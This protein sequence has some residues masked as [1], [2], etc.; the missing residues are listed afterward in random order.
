[1]LGKL[2]KEYNKLQEKHA[3]K[4]GVVKKLSGEN[5]NLKAKIRRKYKML[6]EKGDKVKELVDDKKKQEEQLKEATQK[7][8]SLE[9]E[10]GNSKC[11]V[12]DLKSAK[13]GLSRKVNMLKENLSKVKLGDVTTFEEEMDNL[14]KQV[15]NLNEENK[16]LRQLVNLLNNEELITFENGRFNGDIRQAV[17]KLVGLNVSI[18]KIDL[19][20]KAVLGT[21][22]KTNVDEL[23][24]P[25][26]GSRKKMVEEALCLAQF[27][28]VEEMKSDG[29]NPAKFGNYLHGDDTTKY[30]RHYQHFPNNYPQW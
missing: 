10:L 12:K 26:V 8:I 16:D 15:K 13:K 29:N 28:V 20:I 5:V 7:F 19:V 2:R 24:L 9:T 27:Q 22:T 21:L 14:T 17:M 11:T 3:E 30:S 18:K 23:K 4:Q 6:N 1:M 25:L